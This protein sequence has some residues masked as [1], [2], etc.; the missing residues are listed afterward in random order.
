MTEIVVEVSLVVLF[1]ALSA[2]CSGMETGLYALD[3]LRAR[4]RAEE[5]DAR[6]A[7][8]L[9]AAARPVVA[10]TAILT[11]NN[12]VNYF[13]SDSADAVLD[14]VM[15]TT[16][17]LLRQLA[18][19]LVVAPVLFVVAELGPKDAFLRAP[20]RL[21]RAFE[22]VLTTLIATLGLTLRPALAFFGR[23]LKDE[24]GDATATL[25]RAS[26]GR[27]LTETEDAAS[28]SPSQRRLA[29]RV[30]LLKHVRVEERMTPRAEVRCVAALATPKD[31]ADIGRRF[32]KSRIPIVSIDGKTFEGYVNTVDAAAL[33]EAEGAEDA[34]TLERLAHRLPVIS[35]KAT[36][37]AAMVGFQVKRKPLFQVVDGEGRTVGL[38]AASDLVDALF[39]P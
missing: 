15:P 36:V 7:R 11:A 2:L 22:P 16:D 20:N 1:L 30:L 4:I 25:D 17:L 10:V 9:S 31:A 6:S 33:T 28:L 14:R 19:A 32:G 35:R 12:I 13:V 37:A 39:E 8:L 26:L 34:A 24:E 27:L 3:R 21:M 38:L 29:E 18:D 23:Y 5:G